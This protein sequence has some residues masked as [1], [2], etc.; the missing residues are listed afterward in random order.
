MQ[1]WNSG[2]VVY[3]DTAATLDNQVY[4]NLLGGMKLV[5]RVIKR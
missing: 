1:L 5:R 2:I 4:H 3:S